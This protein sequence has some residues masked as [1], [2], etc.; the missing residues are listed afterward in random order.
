MEIKKQPCG[1][2]EKTVFELMPQPL[3]LIKTDQQQLTF[4][5][6]LKTSNQKMGNA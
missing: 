1:D 4:K 2:F 3:N 5:L 6:P